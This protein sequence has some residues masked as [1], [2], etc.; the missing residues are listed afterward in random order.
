MLQNIDEPIIIKIFDYF[1]SKDKLSLAVTCNK[2]L[3]THNNN[4]QHKIRQIKHLRGEKPRKA[5]IKT[6][7][8]IN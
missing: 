7:K 6:I 3:Q 5:I 8:L 4:I 1:R 2:L